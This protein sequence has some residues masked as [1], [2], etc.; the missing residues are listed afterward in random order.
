MVDNVHN[1]ENDVTQVLGGAF[2]CALN[3][4]REG[5]MTQSSTCL[6]NQ[7]SV[8]S[9][10]VIESRGFD[11]EGAQVL[12]RYVEFPDG[13][14]INLATSKAAAARFVASERRS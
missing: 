11:D 9:K 12:H 5:P 2:A 1:S 13:R 4:F 14:I 6:P 3:L 8:G 10:Y 7:F